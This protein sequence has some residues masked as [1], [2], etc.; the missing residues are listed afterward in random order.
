MKASI[1]KVQVRLWR[2]DVST[3]GEIDFFGALPW[4]ESLHKSSFEMFVLGIFEAFHLNTLQKKAK[5]VT[6]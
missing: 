5:L 2:G 1:S 3:G 6:K 4:L